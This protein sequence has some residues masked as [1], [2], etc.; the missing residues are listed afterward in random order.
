MT[1]EEIAKAI[2]DCSVVLDELKLKQK[3][4]E[5]ALQQHDE[6]L[7]FLYTAELKSLRGHRPSHK[8]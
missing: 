8:S 1:R 5:R 3:A 6:V 2:V 7:Y 4:F